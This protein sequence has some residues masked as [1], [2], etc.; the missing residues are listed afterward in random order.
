M[1]DMKL[2][3]R[4]ITDKLQK[5]SNGDPLIFIQKCEASDRIGRVCKMK[6]EVEIEFSGQL[7]KH[8]RRQ[9]KPHTFSVEEG[10][11][12]MAFV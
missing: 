4:L 10:E 1:L 2:H 12:A 9:M 5:N 11:A 3:I 8:E 6:T 7:C